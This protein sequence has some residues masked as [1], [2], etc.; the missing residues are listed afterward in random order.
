[1]DFDY[2]YKEGI[3]KMEEDDKPDSYE[4]FLEELMSECAIEYKKSDKYFLIRN[5]FSDDGNS[6]SA[7]IWKDD[8]NFK[9]YDVSLEVV[10][11]GEKVLDTSFSLT[12]FVRMLGKMD[13]YIDYMLQFKEIK[14]SEFEQYR[15]L[16]LDFVLF[17]KNNPLLKKHRIKFFNFYIT[18]SDVLNYSS[19][20]VVKKF[21]YNEYKKKEKTIKKTMDII[22]PNDFFKIRC[23]NYISR[24][25]LSFTET[26][27]PVVMKF[28][29]SNNTTPGI[30]IYYP[31]GFKKI[32]LLDGNVR[33]LTDTSD[34][35]YECLYP[36]N[37]VGSETAYVVEGEF[38]SVVLSKYV[39]DDV[40]ALHN[41]SSVPK[42]N[43][44]TNYKNII[45]KLDFDKFNENKEFI[46][47]KIKAIAPYSI[48]TISPKVEALTADGKKMFDYNDLHIAGKMEDFLKNGLKYIL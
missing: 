24:R 44:L 31:N 1:M 13:L 21:N 36:A 12:E 14:R 32:R 42:T 9:T 35:K 17:K 19:N 8:G 20:R 2:L 3:L 26:I 22:E 39:N 28:H 33:Y 45:V 7:Q 29:S 6:Y 16:L 40:Y 47:E 43:Q 30:C 48:V 25:K 18:D 37:I 11:G 34:G 27:K 23:N 10:R 41:T 38:E 15:E 46:L 4:F 5:P